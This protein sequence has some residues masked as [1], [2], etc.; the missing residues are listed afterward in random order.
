MGIRLEGSGGRRSGEKFLFSFHSIARSSSTWVLWRAITLA[1]KILTCS[2]SR[3]SSGRLPS[4]GRRLPLQGYVLRQR[5]HSRLYLPRGCAGIAKPG[6][7]VRAREPYWG[8]RSE[9]RR[10]RGASPENAVAAAG[11]RRPGQEGH[12]APLAAACDPPGP[13][14]SVRCGSRQRSPGQPSSCIQGMA[15]K[16]LT[17]WP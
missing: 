8:R 4:E 14:V 5:L 10:A 15:R 9:P 16:S 11:H 12:H 1:S 7:A 6:R 13:P 2:G 3:Q 17:S